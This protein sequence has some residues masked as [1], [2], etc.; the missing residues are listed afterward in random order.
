M[1]RLRIIIHLTSSQYSNEAYDYP[2]NIRESFADLSRTISDKVHLLSSAT[3]PAEAGAAF[4]APPSSKPQ[5]KTFSHAIARASLAG[6]HVLTQTNPSSA[7][8]DPLAIA[9]EKYALAS[10]KVGEA[11][12]AQDAHI[13]QRFL[14]GWSTTLNTNLMFATRARR[15]VENSRLGLDASKSKA[16]AANGGRGLNLDDEMVT[17][18]TRAEIERKEDEF[19]GQTEEAVGVMKNVCLHFRPL[20]VAFPIILGA[21]CRKPL[22]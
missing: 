16:K 21:F 20:P 22:I 11:R 12:L 5:P 15:G 17:E 2:P 6:S 9:L 18:E 19:V 8:E 10:E 14:A 13:Q 1:P 3:S 7:S 4:T